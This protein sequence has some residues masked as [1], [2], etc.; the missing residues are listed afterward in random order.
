M[1]NFTHLARLHFLQ[2]A[3]CTGITG[4]HRTRSTSRLN[5]N[6]ESPRWVIRGNSQTSPPVET[7]HGCSFWI[8]LLAFCLKQF[9]LPTTTSAGGGRPFGAVV[10]RDGAVIAR[11]VNEILAT[12]DPTSH[13]E[14]NALRAASR[15]LGTPNLAGCEVYASG[16]PCPM[17][18]AFFIAYNESPAFAMPI[19]T[20][21]PSP[22]GSRR[23]P[24]MRTWPS[25]LLSSPW[26]SAMYPL[27]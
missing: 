10:V 22:T 6:F 9:S 1:K 2:I 8:P 5:L 23:P 17:C 25:P 27:A 3:A 11:G 19:P 12:N 18:T 14:L 4:R 26:T 15:A 20:R 13:A 16:Q 7:K 24:S 21:R